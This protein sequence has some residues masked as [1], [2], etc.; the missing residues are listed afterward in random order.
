MLITS[1]WRKHVV[2][3]SREPRGRASWACTPGKYTALLLEGSETMEQ[4]DNGVDST[5]PGNSLDPDFLGN[6]WKWG[7]R[8]DWTVSQM[9]EQGRD[10]MGVC[11]LWRQRGENMMV[12][13]EILRA[14]GFS[15]KC[16]HCRRHVRPWSINASSSANLRLKAALCSAS[17]LRWGWGGAD[18]LNLKT[19]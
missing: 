19:A 11:T 10:D 16:R 9:Q 6:S 15:P 1:R 17:L 7:Q 13:T 2:E 4:T 5:S 12:R 14:G 8:T 3:G 18:T